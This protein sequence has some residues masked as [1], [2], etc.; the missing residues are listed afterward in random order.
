MARA[1]AR[2]VEVGTTNRTHEKDYAA[3]IGART[4]LILKVHTSNYRIQGFTKAVPAKAIAMLARAGHG[5]LR[6]I[7]KHRLDLFGKPAEGMTVS[8]TVAKIDIS[9]R[10]S[11]P[12][13]RPDF[14]SGKGREPVLGGFDSHSLPP[15]IGV[16]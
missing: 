16:R 10:A 11:F 5:D 8:G 4:G 1:G 15:K 2:L 6:R 12:V 7:N 9:G 13:E 3:A 14:K